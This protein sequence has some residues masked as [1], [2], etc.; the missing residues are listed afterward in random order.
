MT[1]I[2]RKGRNRIRLIGLLHIFLS[3][4]LVL[5]GSAAAAPPGPLLAALGEDVPYI[6]TP[7]NVTQAML[8]LAAV[9]AGDHVIDLG[10]GVSAPTFA[11]RTC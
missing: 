11:S 3:L 5:S 7:D 8:D 10:S 9:R 6:T 4:L 2:A 1:V